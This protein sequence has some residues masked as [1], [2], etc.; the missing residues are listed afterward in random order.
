MMEEVTQQQN[1]KGKFH[2][3]YSFDRTL[4]L[5]LSV[6]KTFTESVCVYV[7]VSVSIPFLLLILS[8]APGLSIRAH[9]ASKFAIFLY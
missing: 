8:P 4:K 5:L 1:V 7:C 9:A 2:F 6:A 3:L